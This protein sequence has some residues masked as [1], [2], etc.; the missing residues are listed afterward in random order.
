[1]AT[2]NLDRYISCEAF[3]MYELKTAHEK[4]ED[5]EKKMF[6]AEKM[7]ENLKEQLAVKDKRIID[8]QAKLEAIANSNE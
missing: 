4:L 7:I 8:L 5:K 2:I 3:A 6:E 1:M